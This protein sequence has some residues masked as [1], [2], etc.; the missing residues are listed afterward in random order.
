[1][2]IGCYLVSNSKFEKA[3]LPENLLIDLAKSLRQSG[4]EIVHFAN[5]SIEVEGIYIPAKNTKAS[6]MMILEE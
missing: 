5:R 1:M 2:N 6:I 4:K 3:A